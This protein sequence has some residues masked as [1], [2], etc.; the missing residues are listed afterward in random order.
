MFLICHV[1]TDEHLIDG[2]CKFMGGSSLRY[3][4]LISLVTISIVSVEIIIL[5]CHVT[6]CENL[7]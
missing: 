1:T 5:I 3:V 7:Q 2:S 4:T 6:S